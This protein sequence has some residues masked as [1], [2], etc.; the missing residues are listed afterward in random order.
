MK[1]VY[2]I[3]FGFLLVSI[4]LTCKK[5]HWRRVFWL[6]HLIFGYKRY[7]STYLLTR[8]LMIYIL[9][10]HSVSRRLPNSLFF[11]VIGTV[12]C[13]FVFLCFR[14]VDL[15][16]VIFE[17]ISY[18]VFSIC[19]SAI[20][21]CDCGYYLRILSLCECVHLFVEVH[22]GIWK[23]WDPYFFPFLS[24]LLNQPIVQSTSVFEKTKKTCCSGYHYCTTSFNL[25]WTQVL[26]R[27]KHC[28]RRVRDSP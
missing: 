26:R 22:C 19:H 23:L 11:P 4:V 25:A 17:F 10:Y 8:E 5:I 15:E 1:S 16:I 3:F 20:I 24:I 27:F 2:K 18:C 12:M 6:I 21:C 14:F 13:Y 28:S 9:N 7:V